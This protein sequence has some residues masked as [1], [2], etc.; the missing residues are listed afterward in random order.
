MRPP[1]GRVVTA[2]VTPFDDKLDL[3]YHR[4]KELAVRLIEQGND[5]LVI[6]GTTGESPTLTK[7]EKKALFRGIRET[8]P[9]SAKVIAGTGSNDTRATIELSKAAADCGADGLLLV[10]PY[11]NKP[12]QDMQRRHFLEVAEATTLPIMLYNI[13]GRTAV[14]IFPET[15]AKLAE[16]PRIVAVKQSLPDLDPVSDLAARLADKPGSMF[17]YSGDDSHTLSI[18][19]TGGCGVVSVAGH[20]VGPQMRAMIEAFESGQV[21]EACRIHLQIFPL[22]K[23]IFSTT[24]PVLVKAGLQMVGF[25]VG[26]V[27][28]PLYSASEA[29]EAALRPLLAGLGLL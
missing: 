8:L 23:G 11:Y 15:L 26:G 9:A 14:E 16:H 6:S 25:P 27:R 21:Q 2:M 7:D 20:L 24:N 17:I 18:M 22:I 3:D 13:P 19:S 10:S 29:E 12:T 4:A 28:P 1:F 5:S